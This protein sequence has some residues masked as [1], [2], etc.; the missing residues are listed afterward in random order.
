MTERKSRKRN[1]VHEMVRGRGFEPLN[2]YGTRFPNIPSDVP[3]LR[4]RKVLCLAP[5]T[6]PYPPRSEFG[7]GEQA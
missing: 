2:P 5:L 4:V 1:E 3:E 7:S 6:W